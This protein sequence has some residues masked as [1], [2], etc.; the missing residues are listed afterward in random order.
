MLLHTGKT[1]RVD[2]L[3]VHV[4]SKDISAGETMYQVGFYIGAGKGPRPFK[5]AGNAGDFLRVGNN[6]W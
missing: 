4:E 6:G 1:A 5:S 2:M 3:A